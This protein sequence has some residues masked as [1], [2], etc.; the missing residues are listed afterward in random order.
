MKGNDNAKRAKEI[1]STWPKWKQEY[2]LTK[3]SK[4][5]SMSNEKE[6]VS[7][8]IEMHHFCHPLYKAKGTNSEITLE[9]PISSNIASL[10]KCDVEA[11]ARHF[12]LIK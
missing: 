9:L 10:H 12:N 1:I 5:I 3:H 7:H 11:M 8:P 4:G 6:T 2:K